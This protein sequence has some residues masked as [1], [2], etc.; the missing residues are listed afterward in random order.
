MCFVSATWQQNVFWS[1][2]S[3]RFPFYSN[4]FVNELHNIPIVE[5]DSTSPQEYSVMNVLKYYKS[6]VDNSIRGK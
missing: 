3:R 5:Q 2:P 4:N 1:F 6:F